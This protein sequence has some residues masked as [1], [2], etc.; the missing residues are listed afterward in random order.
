MAAVHRSLAV[1]EFDLQGR[2]LAANDI[3]LRL[4]G[5]APE[6]A[7]G[8][9][10][11][12]FLPPVLSEGA[13]PA[14]LW[15][16]VTS[17]EVLSGRFRR[18][19]KAGREV[20]VQAA[21]NLILDGGGRP[22]KVVEF[23]ADITE[24]EHAR[25]RAEAGRKAAD[26]RSQ[27]A[28]ATVANGL[29]GL[30]DGDLATRIDDHVDGPYAVLREDFN[31]AVLSLARA[32]QAIAASTGVLRTGSQEIASAADD[33]SRRTEHQAATLEE[34]AAAV[35]QLTATVARTAQGAREAAAAASDARQE[36]QRSGEVVQEAVGAMNEIRRSSDQI[37]RIIGVINE[38]AFQTNLLAL[39]AGVEAARAGEAG[40]GFAVVAAEVRALAQRS[41]DAAKEI[42]ALISASADQVSRGVA[43]VDATGEALKSI[44]AR[45][46]QI[47]GLVAEIATSAHEQ[48]A[49]LAEVN[50]AMGQ[51]D[52]VTQ[53]NA[54]M[55]QE[56]TAAATQLTETAG[57]LAE[58]M[59]A[60]RF[61]PP[62]A[63]AAHEPAAAA[64][65]PPSPP[66]Q[67]YAMRRAAAAA[68]RRV[69]DWEEF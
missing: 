6:E 23:A 57:E 48:S 8:R 44:V 50:T 5:Y 10:R 61:A 16:H 68:G 45:A 42:K 19:G 49:G 63:Q 58:R 17:G 55:V 3:F 29:A 46:A 4:V 43:L 37:G 47:D 67:T 7:L 34:T 27:A 53:Q 2:V 41:A 9:E 12:A 35:D 26:E 15:A 59:A 28:I 40:R 62:A 60:F 30:A 52:Q 33:L 39:N 13:E 36:A 64:F 24:V 51:M 20:W 38:I 11:G 1:I 54:A 65:P 14:E 31:E 56:S 25:Q 66:L 18:L 22:L 69:D 21:F 32:L